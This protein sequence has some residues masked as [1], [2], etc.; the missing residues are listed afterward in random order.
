MRY[1]ISRRRRRRREGRTVLQHEQLVHHRHVEACIERLHDEEVEY[2]RGTRLSIPA[3]HPTSTNPTL[4]ARARSTASMRHP[5]IACI[6][7]P[8]AQWRNGRR[9]TSGIAGSTFKACT[10]WT[11][12][13]RKDHSTRTWPMETWKDEWRALVMPV[14]QR[15]QRMYAPR[16]ISY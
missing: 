12:A 10:P 14:R 16:I 4:N 5:C 7:N 11:L 6:V 13:A 1:S 3:P 2:L 15:E 9:R 8:C